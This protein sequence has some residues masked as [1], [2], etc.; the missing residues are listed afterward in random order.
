MTLVTEAGDTRVL[1]GYR[2]DAFSDAVSV[3]GVVRHYVYN[4]AIDVLMTGLV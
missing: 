1:E 4:D 3:N 2:L